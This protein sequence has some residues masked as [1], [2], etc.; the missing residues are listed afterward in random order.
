[1]EPDPSDLEIATKPEQYLYV[2]NTPL[3]HADPTGLRYIF[4]CDAY[5]RKKIVKAMLDA[6]RQ[7]TK[8]VMCDPQQKKRWTEAL[9]KSDYICTNSY[10]E[11]DK[12]GSICGFTFPH[13][14]SERVW[15][16]D[17]GLD[18]GD[19]PDWD[20]GEN[21]MC[22]SQTLAHEALHLTEPFMAHGDVYKKSNNCVSCSSNSP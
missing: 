17:A 16:T 8:C 15:L 4:K 12:D 22:L 10:T 1:M 21:G 2:G 9:L 3:V 11:P 20:C 6:A 13:S 18:R 19:I 14:D 7:L 5:A